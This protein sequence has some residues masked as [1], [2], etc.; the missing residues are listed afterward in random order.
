V[1]PLCYKKRE[2]IQFVYSL[3]ENPYF[4]ASFLKC[5]KEFKLPKSEPIK[6]KSTW[7]KGKMI[8]SRTGVN[9]YQK[10]FNNP[11]HRHTGFDNRADVEP[12]IAKR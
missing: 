9:Q 2:L 7:Y 3:K 1:V 6:T 12:V 11:N 8:N 5:P 10:F 4:L